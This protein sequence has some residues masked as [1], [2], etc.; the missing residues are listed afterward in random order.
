MKLKYDY[1]QKGHY[2]INISLSIILFVVFIFQTIVLTIYMITHFSSFLF[3]V[4]NIILFSIIVLIGVLTHI[5]NTKQQ[6][7][8]IIIKENGTKTPA[9]I[10]DARTI[11]KSSGLHN[12]T[13][14]KCFTVVFDN[15]KAAR[16]DFL[17]DNDAFALLELL[18]NPYPIKEEISIPIDIYIYN[19]KVYADLESVDFTKVSGYEECKKVIDNMYHNE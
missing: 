9:N 18:L 13:R 14:V 11:T 15:D 7:N 1:S 3:F 16:I 8:Q 12:I 10:I 2:N 6:N 5:K 4:L 19:N 17:E